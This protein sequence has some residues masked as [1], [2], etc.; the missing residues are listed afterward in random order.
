VR[1]QNALTAIMHN[2]T[3]LFVGS[4]LWLT[5]GFAITFGESLGD[6]GFIGTLDWAF[7][8]D[9]ALP[10]CYAGVPLPLFAFFQMVRVESH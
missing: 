4:T 1:R 2:V 3:A 6:V 7:F 8:V 9:N 5:L 10:A